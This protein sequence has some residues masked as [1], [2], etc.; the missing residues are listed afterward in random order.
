MIVR[1]YNEPFNGNLPNLNKMSVLD[2][3]NER[4]LDITIPVMKN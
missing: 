2:K 3:K 1:S 4:K